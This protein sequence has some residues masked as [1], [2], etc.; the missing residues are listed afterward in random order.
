MYN[1]RMM[2]L[3]VSDSRRFLVQENGSPFFYLGDTAWEVFH[4]LSRE[5]ADLY[6]H[7]RAAQGFNVIEAVALAE[8]GFHRPNPYGDLPLHD[9]DPARPNDA[10]FS[11]VDWIVSRANELGMYVGFLPTWGDKWSR[12]AGEGPE[13]F[14]PDNARSY[15]LFLGTRY[16]EAGLVWILGGDRAIETDAHRAILRAMADGLSEGDGGTHLRTLHPPGPY[17]SSKYFP[18]QE[19]WIDFHQWQS[20]HSRTVQ[21]DDMIDADYAL[22]PAKPVLDGEPAY[23]DHPADPDW[24]LPG[25]IPRLGYFDDADVRRAAYRAVLAGACGHVYGCHAVWQCAGTAGYPPVNWPR[26]A[27][28]D[29]LNLPGA[30][31]MRHVRALFASRPFLALVPDQSLLA[32][33]AGTGIGRVRAARAADGTYAFVYVPGGG[34]ISVRTERL[35]G[36]QLDAHWFNPRT[37]E[38]T[39][40]GRVPKTE[41]TDFVPPA[42]GIW[43]DWVLV[44][45]ALP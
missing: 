25:A 26:H 36:Q 8:H 20:G 33:D 3:R 43:Q 10:Y 38:W 24:N 18:Q 1:D 39:R 2:P 12:N 15:G 21:N 19:P 35:S 22:L 23:E 28:R 4:R 13:I 29:A 14:T 40:I 31:Q 5:D 11:H 17:S 44:L 42:P 7:T 9:L 30:E 32:T 37:G 41:T 34:N 16:R 27:W 6:L 45:D